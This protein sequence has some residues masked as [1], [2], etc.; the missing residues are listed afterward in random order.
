MKQYSAS[1]ERT[2]D[3]IAAALVTAA[4]IP[5]PS[6]VLEIGSGTGQHVV[7][8][9]AAMPSVTWLPSDTDEA[10]LE[11]IA[12]YRA[13]LALPN[14]RPPIRLD[15]RRADWELPALAAP[16]STILAIDVVATAPWPV[17]VGLINGAGEILPVG[18]RLIL[19]GDAWPR[20]IDEIEKIARSRGFEPD[21]APGDKFLVFRRA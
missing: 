4:T 9:A 8:L 16:L 19:Y 14:L 20:P 11:S 3:S 2:R 21:E 18:G 1:A 13:E 7:T 17:C 10:Q 5:A 12:A 6:T 15:V